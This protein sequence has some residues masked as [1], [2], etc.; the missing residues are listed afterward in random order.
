MLAHSQHS[1]SSTPP[2]S[3]NA[4]S[5]NMLSSPNLEEHCWYWGAAT[6]E[7]ISVAMEV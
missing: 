7:E 2:L 4:T 5:S 1:S 3:D 6:K